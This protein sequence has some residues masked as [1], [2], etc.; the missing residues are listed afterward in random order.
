L[1]ETG[2]MD[3]H[4]SVQ[5][6]TLADET[7]PNTAGRK[8]NSLGI[9]RWYCGSARMVATA[10]DLVQRW[11]LTRNMPKGITH[12]DLVSP[13]GAFTESNI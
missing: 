4:R 13:K 12:I 11:V 10:A 7:H 5:L 9:L 3:H 8:F 1:V 6:V 2:V